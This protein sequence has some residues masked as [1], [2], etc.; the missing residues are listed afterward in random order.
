MSPKR[1]DEALVRHRG[2]LRV[3]PAAILM[4][5][6]GMGA[7]GQQK[8]HEMGL[9]LTAG[10]VE[11]YPLF[12]GRLTYQG[13]PISEATVRISYVIHLKNGEDHAYYHDAF[14]NEDGRFSFTF[15]NLFFYAGEAVDAEA[16]SEVYD[17]SARK[18]VSG[19]AKYHWQA[20]EFPLSIDVRTGRDTYRTYDHVIVQ[21]SVTSNGPVEGAVVKFTMQKPSGP[22]ER[23]SLVTTDASGHFTLSIRMVPE[24]YPSGAYTITATAE[25]AGYRPATNGANFLVLGNDIKL[26]FDAVYDPCKPWWIFYKGQATA[27][28]L[29]VP[30]VHIDLVIDHTNPKDFWGGLLGYKIPPDEGLHESMFITDENGNFSDSW[31]FESCDFEDIPHPYKIEATASKEGFVSGKAYKTLKLDKAR[32]TDVVATSEKPDYRPGESITVSGRVTCDNNP[33]QDWQVNIRVFGPDGG[34]IT[35]SAQE[36]SDENGRFIMRGLRVGPG[37]PSGRYTIQVETQFRPGLGVSR[38]T[39]E[40][41]IMIQE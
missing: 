31:P 22:R 10:M 37:S 18:W 3:W 36:S 40:I 21:G 41:P 19:Y 20:I 39:C 34:H 13:Q 9:T 30:N 29:G 26:T 5:M 11:D 1:D 23:L 35:E 12:S 7:G 27:G 25:K 8:T 33:G 2:R 24:V 17:D 32:R 15:A 14:T 16:T 4:I 28:G 38:A 6:A